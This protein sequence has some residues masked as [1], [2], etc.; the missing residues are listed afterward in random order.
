MSK[1]IYPIFVIISLLIFSGASPVEE[2]D[3]KVNRV[4]IDPGH[5]GRDP[6]NLGTGKY[7]TYEKDIVLSISLKLG[8]YIEDNFDEVEVIYTR[9]KDEFV[10][11]KERA[12]IANTNKADLFICIHANSNKSSIHVGFSSKLSKQYVIFS[13][14]Y[15]LK[16]IPSNSFSANVI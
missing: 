11:L 4:V 14:L 16:N 6:G 7:K 2:V 8:K 10:G 12:D 13:L 9:T 3:Y 5:G 15:M 1:R